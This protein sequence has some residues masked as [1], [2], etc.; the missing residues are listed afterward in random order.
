MLW[1][2]AIPCSLSARFCTGNSSGNVNRHVIHAACTHVLMRRTKFEACSSSLVRYACTWSTLYM[3][4]PTFSVCFI[5]LSEHVF[6]HTFSFISIRPPILR[7]S[8]LCIF[9]CSCCQVQA[10][11]PLRLFTRAMAYNRVTVCRCCSLDEIPTA[12]ETPSSAAALPASDSRT[13]VKGY[14]TI[15]VIHKAEEYQ[16]YK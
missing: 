4:T 15:K 3:V 9:L 13:Q 8:M 16:A 6:H 11:P 14:P 2:F 10:T 7:S 12:A 1:G 5:Q